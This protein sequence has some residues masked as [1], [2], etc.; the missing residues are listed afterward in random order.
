MATTDELSGTSVDNSLR[1]IEEFHSG[2]AQHVPTQDM[3]TLPSRYL[4]YDKEN[5]QRSTARCTNQCTTGALR[6]KRNLSE[7]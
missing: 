6:A 1:R 2:R 3:T 7:M 4:V 5:N